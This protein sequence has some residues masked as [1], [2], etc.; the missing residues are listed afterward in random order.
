MMNILNKFTTNH[1]DTKA[2]RFFLYT[3]PLCLCDFVVKNSQISLFVTFTLIFTV[4]L[5]AQDVDPEKEIV[6]EAKKMELTAKEELKMLAKDFPAYNKSCYLKLKLG[7]MTLPKDLTQPDQNA[8]KLTYSKILH[9]GSTYKSWGESAYI[10]KATKTKKEWFVRTSKGF[11]TL[12]SVKRKME[13][14][15]RHKQKNK[16]NTLKINYDKTK[17]RLLALI[18]NRSKSYGLKK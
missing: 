17:N 1:Q 10:E 11:T 6:Q 3:T 15:V 12:A 2:Q 9:M 8:K 16:Y 7:T 5:H 18:K 4:Q 14:A 13:K